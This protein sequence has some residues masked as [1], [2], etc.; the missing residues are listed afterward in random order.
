MI[1]KSVIAQ[2]A[3]FWI[4]AAMCS[5]KTRSQIA[6]KKAITTVHAMAGMQ[7]L[8]AHAIHNE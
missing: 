5:I 2:L 6:I 3:I 7:V 1:V 8:R 4:L